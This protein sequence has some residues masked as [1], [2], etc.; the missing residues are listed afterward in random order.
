MEVTIEP[1]PPDSADGSALIGELEAE[2]EP[3]YPRA[4]RH[5]YSV[6]RLIEQRVALFVIRCDGEA[7]G[8]GGV[9]FIDDY[10]EIKRMYL[11]P[12]RRGIGLAEQLLRHLAEVATEG[13]ARS[14]RLETGVYQRA[15]I[16]LYEHWGF[17]ECG[18][19]GAYRDDPL[20]RFYC[21]P[22]PLDD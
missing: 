4:S 18:P 15:A 10:A 13:G 5:G 12:Q 19:F 3:L 22:L 21:L 11:R 7:A 2:L 14:L 17:S 9:Q 20:S 8:C 6:E 16:R 1:L